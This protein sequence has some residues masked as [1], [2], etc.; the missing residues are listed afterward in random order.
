FEFSPFDMFCP[1]MGTE[2]VAPLKGGPTFIAL[3][4][5]FLGMNFLMFLESLLFFES[6]TA[7]GVGTNEWELLLVPMQFIDMLLVLEEGAKL[8]QT[9]RTHKF[10]ATIPFP[11]LDGVPRFID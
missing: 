10:P 4:L 7:R 9:I 6:L 3:E 2:G 5:R 1:D 8:L 11:V